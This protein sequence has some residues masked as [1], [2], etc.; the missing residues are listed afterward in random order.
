VGFEGSSQGEES[1][2]SLGER[3]GRFCKNLSR[4]NRNGGSRDRTIRLTTLLSFSR[5]C[6][7]LGIGGGALGGH[8]GGGTPV[9]VRMTAGPRGTGVVFPF[10]EF[11]GFPGVEIFFGKPLRLAI[12]RGRGS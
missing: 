3:R 1:A 2:E 10:G 7:S 12:Q 6:G 5:E 9:G 8:G 4:R 11:L